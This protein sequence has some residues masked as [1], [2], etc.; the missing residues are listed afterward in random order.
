SDALD[1]ADAAHAS[2]AGSG[3][4]VSALVRRRVAAIDDGMTRRPHPYAVRAATQRAALGLPLLPTTTIGALPHTADIRQARA[5]Y[6]RHDIGEIEYLNR[7]RDHIRACVE[8]QEALG[9]DVL[10]HGEAERED[11]VAFFAEQLWG[12][13]ISANGWVQRD[14]SHCVRPPIL[15]G[16]VQRPAPLT[17]DTARFAQ[18]LT[19][20]PMKGMLTG[21]LTMLQW[22]FVRDDQPREHTALQLALALRDEVTELEDAGIRIIQIDE[23]ALCEGL[24]LKQRDHASH[25]AWVARAFGLCAA[26]VGDATQIHT[27]LC[28][29]SVH[30]LLPAIAALDADVM[31]FEASHA[32]PRLFDALGVFPYPNGMGPGV[33]D[34]HAPQPPTVEAMVTLLEHAC[35]V[36]PLERLWVNPDCGMRL[37][38]RAEADAALMGMLAAARIVRQRYPRAIAA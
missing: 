36:I 13:A 30:D 32:D 11:M 20:R 16:D 9:L 4:V 25:L 18:S 3:R 33:C 19:D 23:P 31:S 37:R 12:F 14:G 34:L 10:V 22:S 1:A 38:T 8:Q 17:V 27:H 15:Y 7:I 6:R 26:G 28:H 21:P 35:R 29:A 5:A 2:R 24:P